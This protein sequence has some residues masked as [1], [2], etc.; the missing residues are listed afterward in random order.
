VAVLGHALWQERFD[1]ADDV[2]GGVVI[3]N[4]TAYEIV[5]VAPPGFEYPRGISVWIPRALDVS[6]CGRGCHTM[7]GVGRLAP[8][9]SFEAARADVDRI[10]ANLE[11]SYP[12][13]N[14]GKRFVVRRLKAALVGNVEAGIWITFA[15]A[16]LVLLVTC[17]NVAS[18]LLAEASRR[19]GDVAV[20]AALGASRMRLAAQVLLESG[21]LAAAGAA[22]GVAL[23]FAGVGA[24]RRLASESIPR[25]DLVAIDATVL[26][27]TL[28][29]VA[30][31]MLLF[32]VLPAVTASR[33]PLSVTLSRL[34]RGGAAAAASVRFRRVLLA[35]EV[36]LSV[37]LLVGAG[38]LFRT[39]T[40]LQT[41][42]VGF[43]TR[44]V[45]RFS[46]V[47][48][49]ADYPDLERAMLFYEALETRVAALPGVEA[50]GTMFG[51]PLGRG[52]ATGDVRVEG[53]PVPGIRPATEP[54]AFV[55][56]VTPG[57]LAALRIPLR[58]GR[59]LN[60]ADN[61]RDAEPVALVNE[62]FVREHFPDEDPIGQRVRVTVDFGYGS[63]AW[64]IVGVVGDVR[65]T[66]L[67]ESAGADIYLPHAQYGPLSLTVH[68]RQVPGA[69]ALIRPVRE[70]VRQLD[71]NVP[72]YRV[73]SLAQVLGTATA[74][75]R[76]YLVVVALFAVTAALLAAVGLY[77]VMSQV[78]VQRTREIGIRMALGARR[79]TI[80]GLVV[81]QGMQPVIVGLTIGVGAAMAGARYLESVLFGVQSRDP[82]VIG[83]ATA[84]M[85]AVA[86]LA[87]IIPAIR[88]SG[89]D[90][91][92]V[93]HGQ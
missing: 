81:R 55:R 72:V 87:A 24:L 21:V 66:S 61:R 38:L 2:V 80:V 62:Q 11:R 91:S 17:A 22:G 47:L 37:G 88:A 71:A 59:I 36:A 74:P 65:F 60:P 43:D 14:T 68:V 28:V 15:S 20:R 54:E 73:E 39:F 85:G 78:V 1:A 58:Q 4:G 56:S 8:G 70:I 7:Q 6:D 27:V 82:L 77:G 23:A 32:G 9:V 90:P 44:K 18:L 42:D 93:L 92:K 75:T 76:L 25:A 69:P 84:L 50:V 64:R 26:G 63:P 45:V 79:D 48:P 13:T 51:Q 35:G 34:G 49:Q 83:V 12:A 33:T 86:L 41:V 46:V 5:G 30:A 16:V 10:A 19:A 40:E 31:V 67:T 3:L 57:L 52:R 29:S 89:V 53:R